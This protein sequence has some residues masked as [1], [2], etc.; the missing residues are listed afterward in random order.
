LKGVTDL[1]ARLQAAMD[2]LPRPAGVIRVHRF[3]EPSLGDLREMNMID[4]PI[5][6]FLHHAVLAGAS[7]LVSGNPGVGKT[8][9]LR[10]LLNSIPYNN[11]LVTVEDERELGTHLPMWDAAQQRMVKRHAVCRSF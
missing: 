7:Q 10:A 6:A 2:V 9:M 8:T 11:V 4:T 1:G 3:S 5:Q